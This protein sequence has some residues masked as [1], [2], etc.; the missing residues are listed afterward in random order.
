MATEVWARNPGNYIR[1]VVEVGVSNLTFD[2]GYCV[3]RHLDAYKFCSL[4]YG[5][6][7]PWRCLMVGPQGTAELRNGHG[8][9]APVAVYPTWC[10]GE[11]LDDLEDLM[12]NPVGENSD[13]CSNTSLPVDERP[14]FGQEH[15]VVIT[16]L[17]DMA[18]GVGKR[19]ARQLSE[20][21]S[22]YPECIVM[23][24]GIYAWRTL[25]GMGFRAVDF[26]P[27]GLA[28]RGAVFLPSGKKMKFEQTV[29]VPHWVGL[30]GHTPAD[31]RVPRNRCMFNLRSAL[32]AAEHFEESLRF[33]V[34][35][36][37]EPVDYVSPDEEVSP[38]IGG[39]VRLAART[40]TL[41]LTDKLICNTCTVQDKCKY[42]RVGA[43]CSVPG[44]DPAPLARMFKT[45]DA[46]TIID[47]LGTLLAA[48]SHRIETGIRDEEEYGEL[49]PEVSRIIND[50]FNQ[51]VKLAKLVDPSLQKPN[52]QVN[53]GAGAGARVVAATPAQMVAAVV[54]ALEA[55]GVPR[56]RQTPE[57]IEAVLTGNMD[58]AAISGA[59]VIDGDIDGD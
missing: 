39:S 20:M 35:K 43:V 33:R 40:S 53:I 4:Y 18:T 24:H 55:Q 45:R 48:Q 38:P 41:S 8:L 44:S 11:S 13:A 12:A 42:F 49:S 28:Q 16:D 31:L 17:P 21:Q 59:T 29:K 7:E 36:S 51:A 32:W 19:F 10:Y 47:G 6:A 25:F 23:I 56:D 30:V 1:E 9:D 3:T 15:R 2:R 37:S 54:S 50:T 57:M 5:S 58:Q 26:D 46:Q 52:M 34:V 22:D 14:V 27:R